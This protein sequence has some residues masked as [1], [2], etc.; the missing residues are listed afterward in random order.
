MNPILSS[1]VHLNMNLAGKNEQKKA[2]CPSNNPVKLSPSWVSFYQTSK[3]KEFIHGGK[4]KGF[5]LH[6]QRLLKYLSVREKKK[7]EIYDI[8]CL[9]QQ[10]QV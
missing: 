7:E 9:L 2:R 5:G 3:S 10:C 6:W 4:K 8:I 1:L